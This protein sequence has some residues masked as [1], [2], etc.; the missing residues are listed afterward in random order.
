MSS[1]LET[2]A[3]KSPLVPRLLALTASLIVL[4]AVVIYL[5]SA[6]DTID[7]ETEE[8]MVNTLPVSVTMVTPKRHTIRVEAFAS[9]TP[10]WQ[11]DITS[12]VSG[13]VIEVSMKALAGERVIEGTRLIRIEPSR[14]EVELTASEL[15]VKQAELALWQAENARLLAKKQFQRDG[16]T[17]PNDLALKIPQFEIAKAS[18]RQANARLNAAKQQLADTIITAPFSG[19]VTNRTISPGQ[20]VSVGDKLLKLVDD[21][22]F[23]LVIQLGTRDWALLAHPLKGQQADILNSRGDVVAHARIREAAGFLDEKTRQHKIFLTIKATE[24]AHILS[25]DF[26][27]ISLPGAAIENAI[28]LPESARTQEGYVWFVDDQS[29]L[30]RTSPEILFRSNEQI[31]IKSPSLPKG[32]EKSV[33]TTPLASFLPGQEVRPL[34][35]KQEKSGDGETN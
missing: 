19:F 31:I 16:R 29:R 24:N 7:V 34:V 12:A 8:S 30:Y 32:Q 2:K 3:T 22:V 5:D 11:A 1:D 4:G 18:L 10:R 33:V 9:V 6:Q 25:G 14:Y 35:S 13:R 20:S 21:S 28:S 23:E 17:P 26:L 15:A 27:K